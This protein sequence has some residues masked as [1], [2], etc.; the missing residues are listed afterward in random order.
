[1]KIT[2]RKQA[3]K[4]LERTDV[5]TK[6][7]IK[8]GIEKI[9]VGDIKRLQG[10]TELYRLRIGDWRIVFSNPD[11]DNVVIERISPRGDVYNKGV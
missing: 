10:H 8:Q 1:M 4:E 2:Y 5:S 3:A 9:P 7:R 6:Q 11:N